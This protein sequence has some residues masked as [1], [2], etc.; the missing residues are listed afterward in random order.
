MSVSLYTLRRR[1]VMVLIADGK[2]EAVYLLQLAVEHALSQDSQRMVDSALSHAGKE[3][4][5]HK[6]LPK[7]VVQVGRDGLPRPGSPIFK[8]DFCKRTY[9]FEHELSAPV[10]HLGERE[11][12]GYLFHTVSEQ[13]RLRDRETA[14]RID[15]GSTRVYKDF[16]KG[17]VFNS[18]A[19]FL[20]YREP[21]LRSQGNGGRSRGDTSPSMP[22]RLSKILALIR[23]IETKGNSAS[24]ADLH[25][26]GSLRDK[27][28]ELGYS[29][30]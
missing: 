23:L 11:I 1:A 14:E 13:A 21:Y 27:A 8:W 9:C 19:E 22:P 24:P 29:F 15:E 20:R 3:W 4:E 2:R 28:S 10:G 6:D 5:K 18:G 16:W 12:L 7:F 17:K 30:P 25:F 26:L